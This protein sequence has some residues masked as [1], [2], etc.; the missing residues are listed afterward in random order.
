MT[1]PLSLTRTGS[2]EPLLLLHG[3]GSSR[4]D[5]ATVLEPLSRDFDVLDVDLPGVGRSPALEERPTVAAIA[6]AVELTLDREG[7][8]PVHV[9]GNSLG[10]RVALE[11]ASLLNTER[12]SASFKITHSSLA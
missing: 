9:L 5:F 10:A 7:V 1:A 11:L 2:G 6:D 4:R 12:K 3:M 8:G